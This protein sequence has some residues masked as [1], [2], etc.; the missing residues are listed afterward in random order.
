MSNNDK[1][2]I[3]I[4]QPPINDN[5]TSDSSTDYIIDMNKKLLDKTEQLIIKNSCLENELEESEDRLDTEEK[6]LTYIK[7][8][9]HNLKAINDFY[10]DELNLYKLIDS[11]N[12]YLIK[13][14]NNIELDIID[15]LKKNLIHHIIG[16]SLFYILNIINLYNIFDI[17]IYILLLLS[18]NYIINKNIIYKIIKLKTIKHKTDK[19]T[20]IKFIEIN[21]IQNKI[22]HIENAIKDIDNIIDNV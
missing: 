18:Y 10:K 1:I 12:I 8:I 17:I 2:N 19:V 22:T 3:T 20:N 7:G 16:I 15:F 5:I 4:D 9:L 13:Y 11:N 14:Y 21:E 6:K